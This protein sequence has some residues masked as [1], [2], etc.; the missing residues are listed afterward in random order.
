MSIVTNVLDRLG[1][2]GALSPKI[3]SIAHEL[4]LQF[5]QIAWLK[6]HGGRMWS[7]VKASHE[8]QREVM[9]RRS[10][11]EMQGRLPVAR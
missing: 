4:N 6:F 7:S 3:S 1:L 8:F 10:I 9:V 5:A 11:S 2:T